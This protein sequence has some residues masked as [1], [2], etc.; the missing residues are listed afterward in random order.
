[1]NPDVV[2]ARSLVLS[3][4]WN[5]TSFQIVNPGIKRW[6]SEDGDAVVGFVR[7]PRMRIVVGAPVCTK[8]RLAAVSRAFEADAKAAGLTTCYF[9]A[10]ARLEDAVA[11]DGG[12]SEFLI[13]AQPVWHPQEWPEIVAKNRS[14]RAQ[15][16]RARNKG[17]TVEEWTVEQAANNAQLEDLLAAWLESKGLPPLHFFHGRDRYAC[18]SRTPTHFRR[19]DEG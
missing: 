7:A 17:V 4:G 8:E 5:S 9:G 18:A 14:L 3:H 10:E 15:V 11:H 16:N 19:E 12:H 13:G 1:M 6:F 2:K